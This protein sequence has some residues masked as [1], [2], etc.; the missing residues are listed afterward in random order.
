MLGSRL[1]ALQRLRLLATSQPARAPASLLLQQALQVQGAKPRGRRQAS[2]RA[3]S[4][5]A[6]TTAAPSGMADANGAA[7]G[8]QEEVEALRKQL[9][10]LQVRQGGGGCAAPIAR[11]RAPASLS[12][13]TRPSPPP[14]ATLKAKEAEASLVAPYSASFG[15]TMINSVL[16]SPSGGASLVRAP[17]CLRACLLL[18]LLLAGTNCLLAGASHSRTHASR[19]G[20]GEGAGTATPQPTC[21]QLPPPPPPSRWLPG[22]W[23]RR[24]AWAGG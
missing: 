17:A 19:L 18:L 5:G 9:E 12:A 24:S 13:H 4:V 23:G 15:R 22:R 6:A 1:R 2:A 20:G 3:Q 21:V 8:V 14:Q 16:G 11:M 10:T 7:A